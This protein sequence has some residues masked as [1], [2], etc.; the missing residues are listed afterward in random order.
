MENKKLVVVPEEARYVKF[1]FEQFSSRK[2]PMRRLAV[3]MNEL[4]IK[5]HRGGKFELRTIEYILNNPVYIGKARWTPTGRTRRN[6][7]NPDTIIRDSTHEPIIDIDVWEKA[8]ETIR[9]NKELYKPRTQ[10][11]APIRTWL[12][13]LVRCGVC[14]MILSACKNGYFL[15]NGYGNGSCRESCAI[16]VVLLENAVLEEL[17]TT[18]Q[19]EIEINVVPKAS[20][21]DTFN[22]YDLLTDKLKKLDMREE[23]IKIAFQDGIDT[24]DEYKQNKQAIKSEREATIA[25]LNGLKKTLVKVNSDESI[26]KRM[27]SVY[28]LLTDEKIEMGVKFK[29]AHFLIN[30]IV[31]FKQEMVLEIEYK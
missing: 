8:Q 18:F 28:A 21:E 20:E 17:K 14:G 13:G 4:G 1:I 23:R 12:K 3:Y 19:G 30:N 7:K 22:E 29:T 27:E 6:Y 11:E 5:T 9:H 15:C 16:K 2:M 26:Y 10:V 24:V 31:F 25:K